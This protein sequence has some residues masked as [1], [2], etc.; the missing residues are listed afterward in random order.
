MHVRLP[1]KGTRGRIV[2]V[3][4]H[5][6]E[7]SGLWL[8]DFRISIGGVLVR[9][10]GVGGVGTPKRHRGKGYSRRVMEAT[11][12]FLREREVPLALLFGIRHFY[13]KFGYAPV[14][15]EHK[16]QVPVHPVKGMSPPKG[17]S[18]RR[19]K[20]KDCPAVARLYRRILQPRTGMR[21][22]PVRRFS[23]FR[24]GSTWNTTTEGMGLFRSKRLA[25]YAVVDSQPENVTVAEA[26]AGSYADRVAL[27]YFLARRASDVP[28]DTIT[29]FAPPDD[30]LLVAWKPFGG[31]HTSGYECDG[32]A[33]A[34]VTCLQALLRAS[35]PILV[36][37]LPEKQFTITF[38]TGEEKAVLCVRGTETEVGSRPRGKPGLSI[39]TTPGGLAQLFFG[40]REPKEMRQ[41][42]DAR[43]KGD[44]TLLGT[45]FPTA[46]AWMSRT[47]RF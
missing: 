42:G 15:G 1:E 10:A 2:L 21:D 8:D 12:E 35:A 18:W 14:F 34:R 45:L 27:L 46:Y 44:R 31:V 37:R 11:T 39:S 22:R 17:Y 29:I 24:L 33:V 40:Y 20:E 7:F 4:N 32:G 41:A 25:G 43:S 16:M 30:P 9:A 6:N 19:L 26:A 38:D 36:E 5:S 13:G 23:G 3:D 28:T 47:D